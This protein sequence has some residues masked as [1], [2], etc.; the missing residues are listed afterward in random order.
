ML[1][2]WI[3][4]I[5]EK[6]VRRDAFAC[7]IGQIRH[8][9][10]HLEHPE[11]EKAQDAVTINAEAIDESKLQPGN[12]IVDFETRRNAEYLD[13]R[14]ATRRKRIV[15]DY[16]LYSQFEFSMPDG[17]TEILAHAVYDFQSRVVEEGVRFITML[18][19][20]NVDPFR[21]IN[22]LILGDITESTS[23]LLFPSLASIIQKEK[24]RIIPHHI[25]QGLEITG[26][27]YIPCDIN[28][29]DVGRR[30]TFKRMLNEIEVARLNTANRGYDRMI[31]YQNVQNRTQCSYP[32]LDDT[33]L[34]EYLLQCVIHLYYATDSVHSLISGTS[35][36]DDFYI[37]IGATSIFFDM[38]VQDE[39]DCLT[40]AS[41]MLKKFLD[42]PEGEKKEARGIRLI[43]SGFMRSE[44]VLSKLENI[45]AININDIDIPQPSPDPVRDPF[46]ATL[47]KKYYGGYLRDFPM[48]LMRVIYSH[49]DDATHQSLQDITAD[50]K[51]AVSNTAAAL[52]PAIASLIKRVTP[53]SGGLAHIE[54]E[55]RSLQQSLSA[56]RRK[57]KNTLDEKFWNKIQESASM[58]G[59]RLPFEDYHSAY[60][61]DL[62]SKDGGAACKEMKETALKDL[63]NHLGKQPTMLSVI[64]RCVVGG[65]IFALGIVPLLAAI[66]PHLVDLGRVRHN[67][68]AWYVGMFFVPSLIELAKGFLY[69]RKLH[70]YIDRLK[71]YF[72]HDA[73][74][75]VANRAENEVHRYYDSISDLCNKYLDRIR[76]IRLKAAIDRRPDR[77]L[78][79]LP[80]TMFNIDL[81]NGTFGGF[82][83][84]PERLIESVRIRVAGDPVEIAKLSTQNFFTL[85]NSMNHDFEILF[86]GIDTEKKR[87]IVAEEG[88]EGTYRFL[89]HDEI[90]ANENKVWEKAFAKF[91]RKLI[92]DVKE[93]MLPREHPT[94]CDN[95]LHFHDETD[96]REFLQPL[97]DFAATNG[98]IT[99]ASDPE[100]ADIKSNRNVEILFKGTLPIYNTKYQRD[101]HDPL[102]NR[103]LFLTRWRSFDRFSLNR[104]LPRE[105]FDA[106]IRRQRVIENDSPRKDEEERLPVSS[107]L[108]SALFPNDEAISEWLR[109]FDARDYAAAQKKRTAFQNIMN[110]ND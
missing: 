51:R 82:R 18:R 78:M 70:L 55:I 31:L 95:L 62:E 20:S 50:R 75:R 99:S 43:D 47:K 61:S 36:A 88:D 108:L 66:S 54:S 67:A 33:Q 107:V 8:V 74:A 64:L 25:H 103:Y 29:R 46:A 11:E 73:Y 101:R 86:E 4:D 57:V 85:I 71:S 84:I 10:M 45:N 48:N 77:H 15:G 56:E 97:L 39:R 102:Y 26:A 14:E 87:Q 68:A 38:E 104:I 17:D 92:D 106:D 59:Y 16:W 83:I 80:E 41:D 32:M 52:K 69:R 93:E 81:C 28:S 79:E 2:L 76:Q 89:S 49:I 72:F 27:L 105:D 53:D 58:K 98:E 22:I 40:V 110:I 42:N 19:K 100:Y 96:S 94:V 21:T 90:A 34:A 24:G 60:L 44:E 109:L 37:S 23:Q 63:A 12:E 91:Q 65:I 13:S 35:S 1:P 30:Q 5:R 3:I 7:L 9:C 6:S